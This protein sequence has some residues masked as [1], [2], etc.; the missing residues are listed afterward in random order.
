MIFLF[1]FMF[2]KL[3]SYRGKYI[4]VL[5]KLCYVIGI[6]CHDHVASSFL[7]AYR[8]LRENIFDELFF[9]L[10]A[11]CCYKISH[12]CKKKKNKEEV[13]N[14][15]ID[16][17]RRWDDELLSEDIMEGLNLVDCIRASSVSALLSRP[18]WRRLILIVY[19]LP[20]TAR[21]LVRLD[22]DSEKK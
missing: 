10:G 6:L 18:S 13:K 14:D 1:N 17:Y 21:T 11:A 15:N 12:I 20:S 4:L 5:L 2:F 7:H 9:F 16:N 19:V 8:S 3:F 22:I